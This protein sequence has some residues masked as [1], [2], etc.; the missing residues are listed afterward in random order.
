MKKKKTRRVI[1]LD[2]A[3]PHGMPVKLIIY[4]GKPDVVFLHEKN[5]RGDLMIKSQALVNWIVNATRKQPLLEG[6]HHAE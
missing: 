6:F 3:G 1:K 2:A 5:Q 4:T